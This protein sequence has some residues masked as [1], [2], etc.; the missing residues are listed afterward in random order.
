M[1]DLN[2]RTRNK[3][4]LHENLA[5]QLSHLLSDIEATTSETGNRCSCDV[6]VNTSGRK[7]LTI[8]S[9]HRLEIPNGQTPGDRLENFTCFNN[10]EASVVDY[11]ILSRSLMKNVIN[12]KVLPINFDSK[13]A[14]ISTT[15]KSSFVNFEKGKVLNHPKTYKWDNQG[16]VLLH[17][18]LNQKDT[19]EKLGKLRF[20]LDSSS[21]TNVIQKAVKQFTEIV[22]ECGDKTLRIKKRGKVNKK[23]KNL[24]I[25]RTV[26]FLEN[27][28]P[29]LLS[30]FKRTQKTLT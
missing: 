3:D 5:K 29:E 21:N 13:H 11:L 9:S 23:R 20:D 2:T 7:L 22:A 1:G 12:F 24:V 10:K 17:S 16:A 28:L 27:N 26:L 14:P 6:K 15:F 4:G 19:Q 30:F 18:L 8:C 25:V